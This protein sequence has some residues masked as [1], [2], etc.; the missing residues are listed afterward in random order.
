MLSFSFGYPWFSLF[1]FICLFVSFKCMYIQFIHMYMGTSIHPCYAPSV[2]LTH[3]PMDDPLAD[4]PMGLTQGPMGQIDRW[5]VT[6]IHTHI[7]TFIQTRTHT[8]TS[9]HHTRIP[10]DI[11]TYTYPTDINIHNTSGEPGW[12]SG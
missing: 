4:P 2:D 10:T 11:H 6:S 3:R 7:H 8:H 9:T 5:R 12:L 1:M